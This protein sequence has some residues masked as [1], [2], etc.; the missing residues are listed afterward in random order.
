MINF[1]PIFPLNIVVFPGEPLNLHIFEPRYKQ[2]IQE[3]L[4][5]KKPFGI[6]PVLEGK[7]EE[8]GTLMEIT[9]LVKEYDNGELDIRTKGVAVFRVLEVVKTIPDKLYHGA[10]VDYPTNIMEYGDSNIAHVILNEV[11]RLYTLLNAAE[12]FPDGKTSMISYEV[13]HFVGFNKQQEYELLC[14][15]SEVQR[16]EYI[17]RHLNNML[18]TIKELEEMKARILRNGHFRDLSLEDFDL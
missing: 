17:R 7:I 12:K 4:K 5:D 11:K 6:L 9:E 2:M 15:L 8:Y 18:P 14:L 10:I 16:L 13:A 1:I 3:C